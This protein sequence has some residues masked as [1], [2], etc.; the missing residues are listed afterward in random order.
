MTINVTKRRPTLGRSG[1]VGRDECLVFHSLCRALLI[2]PT[3]TLSLSPYFCTNLVF[4]R[5]AGVVTSFHENHMDATLKVFHFFLLH[6][7]ITYTTGRFI[8]DQQREP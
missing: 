4:L 1:S 3:S 5:V 6:F 2:P 8:V 7:G